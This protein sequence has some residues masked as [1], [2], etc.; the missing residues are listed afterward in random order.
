MRFRFLLILFYT[1][2][3]FAWN[4]LGHQVIAQIAYDQLTSAEKK[5]FNAYNRSLDPQHLR[6]QNFV[7]MAAWLDYLHSRS[8]TYLRRM[9]YI[10]IPL[11]AKNSSPKRLK[12]I[13]VIWAINMAKHT[14]EDQTA[15][16]IDRGIAL[17]ILL[18]V[19]GDVHQPLHAATYI[20]SQHPQGDKGGNLY[21]LY[22]NP[23]AV[24][25]HQYWDQGG[26]LFK[27]AKGHQQQPRGFHAKVVKQLASSL[28]QQWP[29]HL[30]QATLN[31]WQW[32]QESY[33][34]AANQVYTLSE[35]HRIDAQYQY[36]AQMISAERAAEA[37]CR[38]ANLLQR[39]YHQNH[40][41]QSDYG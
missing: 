24:N 14:L 6:R 11:S 35:A 25:L 30:E 29:C 13:H 7:P 23:I 19:V 9:H 22:Q 8:L 20:S 32:A 4:V 36:R 27:V 16:L 10:D 2:K 34:I 3:L 18:H 28:S 12:G 5:E 41:L 1:T 40:D 21:I 26:G 38:L 15:T 33:T 37:G 31:P 39:I 17:R